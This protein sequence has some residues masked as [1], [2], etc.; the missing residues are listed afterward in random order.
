[1]QAFLLVALLIAGWLNPAFGSDR[2]PSTDEI[3]NRLSGPPDEFR[4]R[5]PFT[6]R[7]VEVEG[8]RKQPLPEGERPAPS[9]DLEINF[10]FDSAKLSADSIGLV[11]NLG[12]ALSHKSFE[13]S[14]FVIAGHTDGAGG[15]A[16]NLNLSRRRAQAVADHL[17]AHFGIR[18]GRL[19]VR[20]YGKT[21]LLD[22]S[23]PLNPL[24]R[25]VEIVRLG[26][27]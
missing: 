6:S 9:I 12:R 22:Q 18:P 17:K 26:A 3:I 27:P 5:S 4:S 19:V 16:Y 24:N 21:R 11:A 7:G 2:R 10:E 15:D 1:M 23:N 20:G 14:R 13:T 8:V 25:R